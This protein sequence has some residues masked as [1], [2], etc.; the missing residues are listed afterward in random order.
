MEQSKPSQKGDAVLFS[1]A[2][3]TLVQTPTMIQ[4]RNILLGRR[5]GP[6]DSAVSRRAELPLANVS[7]LLE[8]SAHQEEPVLQFFRQSSAPERV[9][10][11]PDLCWKVPDSKSTRRDNAIGNHDRAIAWRYDR[12]YFEAVFARSADPWRYTTEYEQIKYAQTFALLPERPLARALEIGC[13]EGHFTMQL[14]QRVSDLVTADISHIALERA[15]ARCAGLQ[16]VS[17][18]Q[19]DLKRDPLPGTFDLVVCSEVLYFMDDCETLIAACRKL[20]DA[21]ERGG[22]L[23]VAHANL[24]VDEP[25]TT[26]FDW[27][28]PFGART[29][30]DVI[31]RFKSVALRKEIRTPL[32]RIQLYQ[33]RPRLR[34]PFRRS[35]ANVTRFAEPLALPHASVATTIRWNGIKETDKRHKESAVTTSSLPILMYHHIG[36]HSGGRNARY[37][38]DPRQFEEQLSFLR[39]TGYYSISLD[40]WQ[41]AMEQHEPLPGRAVV[42]TFDDGYRN[43]LTE[44]WPLLKRYGFTAAVFLVSA[45]IG[46]TN[47]WDRCSTETVPLMDWGEIRQLRAAGTEFGAHASNHVRLTSLSPIEIVREAIESRLSLEKGLGERISAFAYPYGAED[48]VIHHLV[49]AC[50][51]RFGLTCRSG[52]SG[53]WDRPLVLP[54]IEIRGDENFADFV[55]K[56]ETG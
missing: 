51:Y 7:A 16:N 1:P 35:K 48:P 44:A 42:I 8:V 11:A 17:F 30:S 5:S 53:L 20:I 19:L 24:V 14:A 47:T 41:A 52:K 40:Q 29:I 9:I 31:Q 39:Q 36:V 49:G 32:Y 55:L 43:F 25:G 38:L 54:R 4:S 37:W 23:L 18:L 3:C 2:T 6:I 22:Y 12:S 26:G 10:Y 28:F 56:L 46:Q 13:A 33:R 50:G 34:L 21:L 27:D 15:A 45:Q